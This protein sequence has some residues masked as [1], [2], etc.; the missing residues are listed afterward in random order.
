MP[1]SNRIDREWTEE[2]HIE[3]APRGRD[4]LLVRMTEHSFRALASIILNGRNS[5]QCRYG[6]RLAHSERDGIRA[7]YNHAEYLPER[8][9]SHL[10]SCAMMMP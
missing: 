6:L 9:F 7:A 4:G 3:R 8:G 5:N 2:G 1:T 10:N